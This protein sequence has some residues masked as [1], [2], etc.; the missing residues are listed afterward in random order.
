[1]TICS[2]R[3]NPPL[4]QE[5]K[6]RKQCFPSD[7]TL[8]IPSSEP[9]QRQPGSALPLHPCTALFS[10]AEHSAGSGE[11]VYLCSATDLPQGRSASPEE[12]ASL[13]TRPGATGQ[14]PAGKQASAVCLAERAPRA[15]TPQESGG[16]RQCLTASLNPSFVRWHSSSLQPALT[17][18][19][20]P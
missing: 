19:V 9:R 13:P 17:P 15:L 2:R 11:R 16:G 1:L 5:S 12:R 6:G 18:V 20:P 7:Q 8:S 3:T 14:H 10:G 4:P